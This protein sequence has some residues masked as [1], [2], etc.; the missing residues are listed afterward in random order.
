MVYL[1]MAKNVDR[2]PVAWNVM[3]IYDD[4]VI[5]RRFLLPS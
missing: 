2:Q 5:D 3:M 4:I 1:G